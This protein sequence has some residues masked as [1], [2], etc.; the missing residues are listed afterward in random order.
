[1][2]Q[3]LKAVFRGGTFVP[4]EECSLPEESEVHLTVQGPLTVP[5]AVTD[6]AE[7]AR[8]L[9]AVVERM[10]QNPIPAAAPRF[11]REELHERR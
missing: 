10:R 6:R 3:L 1:M 7:R 11:T 4:E 2:I 8:I 9:K 5:P